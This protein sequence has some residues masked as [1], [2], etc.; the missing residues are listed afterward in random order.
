M[1]F[2]ELDAQMQAMADA[3]GKPGD[4]NQ[5]LQRIVLAATQT[6][7]GTDYASITAR[8]GDGRLETLT[9][10]DPLV[11]EADE[12][13][14]EL[15]EGP[16]YDAVTSDPVAYSPDLSTDL[17]WPR[18]GPRVAQLG[19]LSQKAVRMYVHDGTLTGLN[20]YS[21]S[22]RAF[23]D[24]DGLP[25]LFASHASIALGYATELQSLQGAIGTR[26]TIGK[27]IGI[28]MER[29]GLSEERA[30]EFLI[31]LSQN[32]NI[33]LRDI[34]VG[35]INVRPRDDDPGKLSPTGWD[36]AKRPGE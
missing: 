6:V 22:R 28:I 31:R 7:P 20:L 27:A 21:R 9:A 5:A 13:Q 12:L 30:F 24:S 15:R 8:R 17:T 1:P 25:E 35:V 33:K 10:T 18:Y 34:A 16:C 14:Y 11:E 3:L 36:S 19:L 32:S 23:E 4:L 2:R 26:E 29:Y